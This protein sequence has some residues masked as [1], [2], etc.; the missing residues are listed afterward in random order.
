MC[1]AKASRMFGVSAPKV[2]LNGGSC[3]TKSS[4]GGRRISACSCPSDFTGEQCETFVRTKCSANNGSG[5]CL[6]GGEC[7]EG[8]KH[9]TVCHCD[10]GFIGEFCEVRMLRNAES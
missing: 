3:L 2:C 5:P 1:S 10:N 7:F 4:V 9:D 8:I 6:N